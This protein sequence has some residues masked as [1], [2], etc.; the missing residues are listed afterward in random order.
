MG[1]PPRGYPQRSSCEPFTAS[2]LQT[3]RAPTSC[4]PPVGG[5]GWGV[6]G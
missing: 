3:P 2:T 5:V 1:R 6:E 4:T